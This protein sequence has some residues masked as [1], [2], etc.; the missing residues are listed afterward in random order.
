MRRRV[1]RLLAMIRKETVQTLRDWPTLLMIITLPIIELFLFAYVG[2]MTLQNIPTAVADLSKDARSR[3]FIQALQTSGSFAVQMY[4]SGE[5]EIIHAIEKGQIGAGV[6]IPPDFGAQIERGAAQA[7]IILD[8]S[9]SFTVQSGYS[10]ASA[11]AQAYSMELTIERAEHWGNANAVRLPIETATRILYNPNIDQMI[12]LIPGIAASLLQLLGVNIT[13]MTIIR[14]RDLG[15]ME[16]LL[17]TPLRPIEL[18][19]GKLLPAVMI[20]A[21]DLTL[22]ILLGVYWFNVPFQGSIK[23][24]CWLALIFITSSLGLGLLLST[25]AQSQRQANQMTSVL[26]M[27]TMLLTGL[28]YPRSTM[29]PL[30]RAL[31]NLIPATYFIRISRGIITKGVG[32]EFMWSDVLIMVL[33]GGVVVIISA[34]SFKKRLD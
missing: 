20:A 28:V 11:I 25:V 8:G 2:D 3:D 21:F 18:I 19:I 30:I 1:K 12:F 29:P 23:L 13:V 5:Q 24:F 14:E 7:L 4:L 10:A 6:V 31:G 32:I 33:Y 26:M 22:I 34:M 27:L 9:D 17:V 16:Q 15:T